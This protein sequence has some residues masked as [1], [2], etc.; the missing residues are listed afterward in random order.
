MARQR[1]AVAAVVQRP[2][3]PVE[4]AYIESFN[5]RRFRDECLNEGRFVSMRHARQLIEEWRIECNTERSHSLLGYRTP[6]QFAQRHEQ[7]G[8]L[9]SDSTCPSY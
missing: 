9:A 4:N 3:R 1:T 6:A 7:K 5:G 2:G 8:V